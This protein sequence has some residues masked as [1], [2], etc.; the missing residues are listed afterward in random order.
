MVARSR[1][2][3]NGKRLFRMFP[4]MDSVPGLDMHTNINDVPAGI[5]N[6]DESDDDDDDDDG[7]WDVQATAVSSVATRSFEKKKLNARACT[8]G[9]RR[10][11]SKMIKRVPLQICPPSASEVGR[12]VVSMDVE[13]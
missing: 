1:Y 12:R 9:G 10:P 7:S 8:D 5:N 11:P 2:F 6:A 13:Y 4:H 3:N